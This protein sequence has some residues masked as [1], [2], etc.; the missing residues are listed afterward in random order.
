MIISLNQILFCCIQ[1]S[2]GKVLLLAW[3]SLISQSIISQNQSNNLQQLTKDYLELAKDFNQVKALIEMMGTK[4]TDVKQEFNYIPSIN[5]LNP[6]KQKRVSSKFGKRF[7]PIDKKHK[8]HLGLD[9]SAASGTPIHSTAKGA[10]MSVVW[11]DKGYGNQVLIKHDFGFVTRYA[12]MFTIIVKK[13][14]ELNKGDIIGFV[15]GT[16]KSTAPH[17][18]YE[19]KKHGKHLDPYPFC[20]LDI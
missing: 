5:P 9:I 13:G 2:F 16:G 15:G 17:I 6:K 7:H 20:F 11:S 8:M 18:H 10:V 1:F 19:V 3:F 4:I 12:H 14:Q